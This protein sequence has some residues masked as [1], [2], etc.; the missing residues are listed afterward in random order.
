M[1]LSAVEAQAV[2]VAGGGRSNRDEIA[3]VSG[4]IEGRAHVA[5]SHQLLA[6]G[7]VSVH[8]PQVKGAIRAASQV[9]DGQAIRRPPRVQLNAVRGQ[10]ALWVVAVPIHHV[11]AGLLAFS[12]KENSV[13]TRGPC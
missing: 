6:V 2:D 1:K 13:L 8:A 7:A 4:G 9:T 10:N 5:R 11:D 12:L 3:T